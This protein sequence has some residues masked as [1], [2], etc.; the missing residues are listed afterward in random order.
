MCA[1]EIPPKKPMAWNELWIKCT[2]GYLYFI[3]IDFCPGQGICNVPLV[4]LTSKLYRLIISALFFSYHLVKVTT[5]VEKY[6][7][8]NLLVMRWSSKLCWLWATIDLFLKWVQALCAISS[9]QWLIRSAHIKRH[10]C[11]FY[12]FFYKLPIK[13]TLHILHG[14]FWSL[15][16]Q[17]N[18]S[19]L[20]L[21][22]CQE[23]PLTSFCIILVNK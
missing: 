1:A 18:Q 10:S 17:I 8:R 2:S 4:M 3:P 9:C 19:R 12:E 14:S 7:A 16:V 11:V 21:E 20:Y 23:Y 13:C 6:N 5:S 15:R 22:L